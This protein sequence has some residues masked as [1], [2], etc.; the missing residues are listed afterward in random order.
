MHRRRLTAAAFAA[1]AGALCLRRD[2]TPRVEPSQQR[3]RKYAR[4]LDKQPGRFTR[5]YA[6]SRQPSA[7]WGVANAPANI[8]P[9]ASLADG[10][11]MTIKLRSLLSSALILASGHVPSAL[12]IPHTEVGARIGE[13]GADQSRPVVVYCERGGRAK[14]T[15]TQLAS[16]GFSDLRHLQG[17]MSAW[18]ASGRT[19]EMKIQ[20]P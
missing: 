12:N 1:W 15:E 19:M 7:G 6:L 10:L 20:T 5:L 14:K 16:A 17:D 18:R 11:T 13:L 4:G 9:E 3:P 2:W 8:A